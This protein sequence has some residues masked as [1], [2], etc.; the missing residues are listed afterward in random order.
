MDKTSYGTRE[1]ALKFGEQ[2]KLRPYKCEFCPSWHLSH[3]KSFI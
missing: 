2:Y 1:V 3:K